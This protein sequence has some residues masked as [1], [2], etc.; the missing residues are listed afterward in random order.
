MH[1]VMGFVHDEWKGVPVVWCEQKYGKKEA[2]LSVG[3]ETQRI[4]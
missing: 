2:I 3:F 1:Q 4:E